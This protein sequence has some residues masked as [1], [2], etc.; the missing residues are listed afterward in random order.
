MAYGFATLATSAAC[1]TESRAFR[2][3]GVPGISDPFPVRAD[4]TR[5]LQPFGAT[6]GVDSSA[7][8]AVTTQNQNHEHTRQQR[9]RLAIQREI[10]KNTSVE[11]AYDGSFSDRN[12]ISIRQ[13]YLPQ[14]YWIPGSLNARDSATQAALVANV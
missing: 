1:A 8:Q 10:F 14:Q 12:E 3:P 11:L 9:W 4:G 13:D 5:F 6:L 2:L 7:G